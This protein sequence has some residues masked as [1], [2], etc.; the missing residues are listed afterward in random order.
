MGCKFVE[1]LVRLR[2]LSAESVDNTNTFDEFKEYIHVERPV[3][4]ELCNLLRKLNKTPQKRLVLLCGSA[5]DGKSHLLSY[6][7]NVDIK[8]KYRG[9]NLVEALEKAVQY[10]KKK[11]DTTITCEEISKERLKDIFG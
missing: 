9:R 7:K 1:Q 2:K 8:E 4:R 6:L 3:E 11:S 5:G 10:S